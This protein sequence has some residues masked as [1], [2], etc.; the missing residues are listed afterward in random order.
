MSGPVRLDP[1]EVLA[2]DLV[3]EFLE[4]GLQLSVAGNPALFVLFDQFLAAL[5]V[6]TG[7]GVRVGC[8]IV[9]LDGV[10]AGNN[11]GCHQQYEAHEA[12]THG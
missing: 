4:E 2:A 12:H 3:R 9:D 8:G 11:G 6:A 10:G 5:E 7:A 1:L